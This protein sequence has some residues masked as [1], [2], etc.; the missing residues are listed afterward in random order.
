MIEL[1]NVTIR[2]G[3]FILQHL[4]CQIPDGCYAVLMGRTGTGKTTLLEAICGL[5]TVQA[6]EIHLQGKRM[7][8]A[9]PAEREIGY[10]PQDLALFPTMTVREHLEFALRVRRWPI[11]ALKR[12]VDELAQL[13]QIEHLLARRVPALSGG[14]SQRIAIGRALSFQPSLLLLDE[15]LSA[16][17]EE[18]RDQVQLLLQKMHQA[19]GVTVLHVTHNRREAMQLADRLYLLEAGKILCPEE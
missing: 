1:H 14:E 12:R 4:S 13:L 10:V 9:R 15:P 5:R 8:Q 3:T 19:T 16:L 2:A 11:T 17:D 6:G 7:T 18:T